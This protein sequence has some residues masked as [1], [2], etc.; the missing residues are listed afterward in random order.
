M[1]IL[2]CHLA[3]AA[4]VKRSPAVYFCTVSVFPRNLHVGMAAAPRGAH[5]RVYFEVQLAQQSP[6]WGFCGKQLFKLA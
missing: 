2:P 5:G 6:N 3:T 4:V 1:W